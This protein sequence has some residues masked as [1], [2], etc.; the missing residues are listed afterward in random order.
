MKG[1]L[2]NLIKQ[3]K[4]LNLDKKLEEIKGIIEEHSKEA[5][6]PAPKPFEQLFDD[7]N[8][9]V[10]KFRTPSGSIIETRNQ[11]YLTNE[12]SANALYYDFG[13]NSLQSLLVWL[14]SNNEKIAEVWQE[15]YAYHNIDT[16]SFH[17]LY[18]S[19]EGRIQLPVLHGSHRTQKYRMNSANVEAS[20]FDSN[21]IY[22]NTHK[23]TQRSFYVVDELL[24][25]LPAYAT[26]Q[27]QASKAQRELKT[28][29][30]IAVQQAREAEIAPIKA[31]A[32]QPMLGLQ[33]VINQHGLP[34]Q[35]SFVSQSGRQIEI[36]GELVFWNP[37]SLETNKRSYAH[38]LALKIDANGEHA[39][40][41]IW[42]V[43]YNA[44]TQITQVEE[45]KM[46]T[47][48]LSFYF[49]TKDYS[50]YFPLFF[51]NGSATQNIYKSEESDVI[52]ADPDSYNLGFNVHIF[53]DFFPVAARICLLMN[54][55]YKK[56]FM[57]DIIAH[58]NN[59]FSSQET[60]SDSSYGSESYE[61]ISYTASS[62]NSS[63]N[64]RDKK[65]NDKPAP[66]PKGKAKNIN[67]KIKND[68]DDAR[69]VHNLGSGGTYKLA[70]NVVT[71]IKMDEDDKLVAYD[72]GKKGRL[73]LVAESSMEGKVQNYSKI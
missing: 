54:E 15:E 65:A 32:T 7:L 40:M 6:P 63:S 38:Y 25:H 18:L 47:K 50:D 68:T 42:E 46:N 33:A 9:A 58:K 41:S 20:S 24:K 59:T 12:S 56:C 70:K 36:T 72:G 69:T 27:Y 4:D 11:A 5:T 49:V 16:A 52:G 29:E 26:E 3:A 17:K 71:T 8:G 43:T 44:N 39:E 28:N 45:S 2:S 13:P 1:F 34:P 35:T 61:S 19:E 37:P 14:D 60:T 53:E 23:D 55:Y 73:L 30:V 51:K 48:N 31:L 22:L 10:L 62:P 66:A 21:L 57:D 64:S 67:I